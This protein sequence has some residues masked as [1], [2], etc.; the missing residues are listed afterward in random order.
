MLLVLLFCLRA[1]WFQGHVA[2]DHAPQGVGH[3]DHGELE[4]AGSDHLPDLVAARTGCAPI[5]D[6]A[7]VPAR[8]TLPPPATIVG[9]LAAERSR[10]PRSRSPAARLSRAPPTA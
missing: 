9:R 5:G 6:L 3:G 2:H 8:V 1:L 7:P 10:R 4:H